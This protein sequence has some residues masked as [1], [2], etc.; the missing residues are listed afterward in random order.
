MPALL[1]LTSVLIVATAV[2]S[3]SGAQRGFWVVAVVAAFVLV[4]LTL[5]VN[6]P[7]N[8]R[9]LSWD[10]AHPPDDWRADPHRWHTY[11]GVRAALLAV[12]FLCAAGAVTFS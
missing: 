12:W 3:R 10:A 7:I 9:T 1:P 8:K 2:T 5:A 4:A 11:Q 6:V